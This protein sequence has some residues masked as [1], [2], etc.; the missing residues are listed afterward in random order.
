MMLALVIMPLMVLYAGEG[1]GFGQAAE[2]LGAIEGPYL[3]MT[4]GL[5]FI[6]FLSAVT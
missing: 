5:T 4:E 1:G 3:S 2:T 6:G